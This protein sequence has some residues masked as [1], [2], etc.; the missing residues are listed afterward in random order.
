M[1]NFIVTGNTYAHRDALRAM[2][3]R[4]DG[5]AKAWTTADDGIAHRARQLPGL[6]V[7]LAGVPTRRPSAAAARQA[8]GRGGRVHPD[9][10]TKQGNC[11]FGPDDIAYDDI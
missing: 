7:A 9:A 5:A 3:C 6:V 11:G 10:L 1:T 8:A 4:W 2:G